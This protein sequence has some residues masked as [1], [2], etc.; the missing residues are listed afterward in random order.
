MPPILTLLTDFGREDWYVAAVHGV[1]LGRAP[2]TTIV[3]VAHDLVP[4]DVETASFLLAAAAPSFPHGTVHLAV[5]DPGVGSDR[6]M[7][8][9]EARV[10]SGTHRFVAPDNGLLEPFLDGARVVSI[11]RPD[12]Y[13][14]NPGNTFHGRDRFAPAAAFLL[15]GGAPESLG[16]PVADPVR[17]GIPEPRR[18]ATRLSGRVAHVDRYGNL[19]TDLPGDWL[20]ANAKLRAILRSSEGAEAATS[21][22]RRVRSYAELADGEA[23]L[24]EGSLGTIELS[25][26]GASLAARWG[27]KRGSRIEIELELK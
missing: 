25:L 6:R 8:A 17:L 3:D 7:L 21:A 26:R 11:E 19:V 4:G 24:L 18:A 27:I 16:P 2:G 1:L 22:V 15:A 9:V 12:L 10:G 14:E 20:E 5:V 23:G 13:L